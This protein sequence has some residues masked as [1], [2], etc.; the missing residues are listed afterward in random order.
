MRAAQKGDNIM[1]Q[2]MPEILTPKQAAEHL[3]IS[4]ATLLRRARRGEIQAAMIGRQW[5]FKREWLES[6]PEKK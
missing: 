4:V 6:L 1:Q 5:R 3:H 2:T